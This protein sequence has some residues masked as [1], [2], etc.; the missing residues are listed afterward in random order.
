MD[1][2]VQENKNIIL[3]DWLSFSS[4]VHTVEQIKGLLGLVDV[5]YQEIYG[6]YGYSKRI[7]YE[8][9]SILFDG[10]APDMGV[11][12]DISGQGC[13]TFETMGNGDWE[14]L[15]DLIKSG[16]EAGRMNITRLDIAYD[17]HEGVLDITR[18]CSDTEA[19]NYIS[20]TRNF[21]VINSSKGKTVIHGSKI[22]SVYIR[23]YDKAK[24]RGYTDGRH[25]IRF[26]IQLRKRSAIGFIRNDAA[27][28]VKFLGVVHNYLRYV[29]PSATDT[30]KHRWPDTSYWQGFVQSAAKIRIYQKPGIEYNEK[31]LETFVLHNSGNSINV[32]RKI[33]G[34]A[35][36]L[37][38]LDIRD[39]TARYSHRQKRLIEKYQGQSGQT[40]AIVADHRKRDDHFALML[41][42]LKLLQAK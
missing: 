13:R 30:N 2:K 42:N 41:E 4:K 23:I 24:E 20:R 40:P 36:L 9:V 22:S 8:G 11:M 12:V 18:M 25:W 19:G 10:H 28:G 39:R 21:E 34:D 15:F 27:I 6:F 35:N 26:E 3:Y 38:A 5:P 32:F 17:D 14:A 37:S 16:H 29:I 31:N 7:T 33:Y 1:E